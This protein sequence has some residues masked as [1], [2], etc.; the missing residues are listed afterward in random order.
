MC[1]AGT[2]V[3]TLQ[4][5]ASHCTK[6]DCWV[7]VHGDVYDVTA[8][9]PRHPGGALIYVKAGGD[10]SQLFD[11][12][13]T[14]TY[15]RCAD[16]TAAICGIIVRLAGQAWGTSG[17]RATWHCHWSGRDHRFFPISQKHVL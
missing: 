15:V 6:D 10:C 16:C 4:E 3:V 9:V 13:H 2:R 11:S 7:I 5:V 14:K 12:Y 1:R 17:K 8:Y